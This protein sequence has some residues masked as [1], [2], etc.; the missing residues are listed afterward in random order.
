MQI[1]LKYSL[2]YKGK[3]NM[4]NLASIL[5]KKIVWQHNTMCLTLTLWKLHL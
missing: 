3:C 2:S 4:N 1:F 5:K